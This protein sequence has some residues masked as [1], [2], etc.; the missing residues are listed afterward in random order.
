MSKTKIM[1]DDGFNPEIVETAMFDG[2]LEMP[3]IE[4]PKQIIL[5]D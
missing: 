4:R 5:P 2:I 1:M 3:I